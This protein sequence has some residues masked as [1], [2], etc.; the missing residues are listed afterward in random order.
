MK[1]KELLK[2]KEGEGD[3]EKTKKQNNS[4]L[5]KIINNNSTL[6]SIIVGTNGTGKSTELKKIISK[7]K[8]DIVYISPYVVDY[9][10]ENN[11]LFISPESF[12]SLNLELFE[13]SYIIFDD[14]KGYIPTNTNDKRNV[15]IKNLLIQR[16][17]LK[18]KL[19]FVFHGLLEIPNFLYQGATE[20]ILKK[21][22]DE[23]EKIKS[24]VK[25]F[26]LI[27]T[28]RK[29]VNKDKNPYFFI[30]FDLK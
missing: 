9:K 23:L 26:E 15:K 24:S 20:M 1:L 14:C 30:K 12:H 2:K 25:N 16:R 10:H 11:I 17:Y 22:T 4:F 28:Y 21:T 8:N 29:Q 19:Y 6:C 3:Q 5:D 18:I 27:D 7:I 13:N